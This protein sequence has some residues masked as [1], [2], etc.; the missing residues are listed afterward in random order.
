MGSVAARVYG[1]VQQ[2]G[3]RA[4]VKRIVDEM[5]IR[6]MVW[7][8]YDGM[9]RIH[10]GGPRHVLD[11]FMERIRTDD[12]LIRIEQVDAA[13][14]PPSGEYL[15]FDK[16]TADNETGERLDTAAELLKEL[17]QVNRAGF[18]DVRE[19]KEDDKDM[20]RVLDVVADDVRVIRDRG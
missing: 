20:R 1:N 6:G 17:I 5:G 8:L 19:I 15:R 10:A 16:M 9:V 14:S 11:S 3:Y 13:Y 18:A 12:A 4:R 7:N 2:V